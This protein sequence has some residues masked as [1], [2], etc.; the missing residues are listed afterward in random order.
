MNNVHLRKK[1]FVDCQEGKN[2]FTVNSLCFINQPGLPI[3]TRAKK[4][5][6]NIQ[7]ECYESRPT[8]GLQFHKKSIYKIY[9]RT[10]FSG[11]ALT[12]LFY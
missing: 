9:N 8:S 1:A 10:F 5:E 2:G 3:F 11:M 7:Q 4:C 6:V 12:Y